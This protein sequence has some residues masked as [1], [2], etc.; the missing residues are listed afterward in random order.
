[1]VYKNFTIQVV[2]RLLIIIALTFLTAYFVLSQQWSYCPITIIFILIESIVL[3]YSF[4]R[5]NRSLA[6]FFESIENNDTQLQFHTKKQN[7]SMTRLYES[8]NRVNRLIAKT[9]LQNERNEQYYKALIQQSATGLIAMDPDN[10]IEIANEK[11]CELTGINVVSHF[12]RLEKKNPEL[13]AVLCSVKSGE[14]QTIKVFHNGMYLHL[15]IC[16]TVLRFSGNE[17]K[18]ISIQ[19][20]KHELEAKE[21]ESWQKLISILTHEIMNSIAPITSLTT[22]LT[23]FFKRNGK[24][25]PISEIDSVVIQNT[26]QGLEIIGE[27]GNGLLNF[28]SNYRRLT[29]VP[30]P[31]FSIFSAYEWLNK[32]K[33]LLHEKLIEN[34]ISFEISVDTQAGIINGDEKL[35]TQVLI[36]LIYNA[37][38]AL[39]MRN[40]NRKIRV[41]IDRNEQKQIQ[42][43]VANNGTMVPPELIDKL[44]VPFFTT[45]ENGSGIGLNLSR[46]IVQLHHGYIYLESNETITRFIIVL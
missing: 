32:L 2:V 42:I 26:I 41:T 38:D 35:L 7:E 27:R 46:Q 3:I 16:A 1:M 22:T 17:T 10:T 11:A 5:T 14:T 36:N 44:F 20:I 29:K 37:I 34:N 13:W 39:Q 25:V 31:V 23:K 33:I 18:L 4:N 6:Y 21:M 19:D 15:S 8:M 28:V 12:S 9:K 24:P 45:R 43:T 30:P 40:E